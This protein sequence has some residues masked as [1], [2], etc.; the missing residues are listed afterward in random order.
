MI[1]Q[2][3]CRLITAHIPFE[4]F[5]IGFDEVDYH[6]SIQGI[7]KGMVQIEPDKPPAQLQILP[8]QNGNA[9]IVWFDV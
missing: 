2:E 5:G 8:Y 3:L 4:D 9:S 1:G 6:Q 7:S